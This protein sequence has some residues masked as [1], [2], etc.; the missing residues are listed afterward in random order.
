MS[1]TKNIVPVFTRWAEQEARTGVRQLSVRDTA[2]A[3]IGRAAFT[4]DYSRPLARG[5]TLL[6]DVIPYDRIWRTGANAATQF[7]T[8]APITLA[9]IPLGAGT[10]TLWTL[11]HATGVELIVNGETGQW[12]TMYDASHDVGRAALQTE[13]VQRPV[14]AFTISVLPTDSHR[15]TLALAWG[16]FR[17]T[18]PIVVQ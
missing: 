16:P 13:T 7:S 2:R 18:A 4:V 9:G 3:T 14:E 11:P 12:G 10:Y 5:R 1:G 15:G 17:W 6:G 8:T